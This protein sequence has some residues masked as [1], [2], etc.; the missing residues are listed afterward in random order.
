MKKIFITG[1]TG[2]LGGAITAELINAGNINNLLL[3]ARGNAEKN[4]LDRIKE[5]LL[6]FCITVSQ[7]S[8]L[9]EQQIVEGDLSKPENFIADSRLDNVEKVI[10]CAAIASFGNNPLIW[11]VNVEGTFQLASR[12]SKVKGLKRFIHVGT[13]MSCAPEPDTNV[14][15]AMDPTQRKDHIVEYTWSKSTIEQM[16]K[17]HLPGFPLIIA[18]PSIVV[19]HTAWVRAFRQHLLGVPHGAQAGQVHVQS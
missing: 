4:A 3:L 6:K 8:R 19:G 9:T 17:E 1:A 11:K 2:F 10:N 7:L 14:T 16:I 5:N 12:M 15:E 18:R 13:A